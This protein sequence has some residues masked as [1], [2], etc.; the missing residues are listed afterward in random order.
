[1]FQ[2]VLCVY[3]YRI[4]LKR[5]KF[6]PP[7][8]IEYIGTVVEPH[9][10]ALDIIDLRKESACTID[11]LRPETDMVCFSI[12]WKRDMEFLHSE[13]RSVPPDILTILGGQQVTD[14]PESWFAAL[15][16]VDVIVRGEGEEIME[17]LC[18]G[19]PLENI[20]GLSFRRGDDIFHN[21][22][23]R[24]RPLSDHLYPNRS[25]RR[26]SYELEISGFNTGIEFDMLSASR[27]CPFKCT[28]CSFNRN[29]WGQ[30]RNWS[31]RSPES[32]VEELDLIKAPFIGLSDE[33]FTYDMDWVERICDLILARGIRKK[34]IV[35]ARLEI[36]RRP[37]VIRKMEQAGFAI[38]MLGVE[39]AQDKTLRSMRKGFNTAKIRE[40][41][42]VLRGRLIILHG[43]FILG[44]IGESVSEMKQIVP[45]ARELGLDTLNLCM[46]HTL[47]HSGIEDMVAQNPNYHIASNGK[48]YSDHCSIKEL[49]RLRSNLFEQFY[50]KRQ[51][52]H[53]MDKATRNGF[54][55]HFPQLLLKMPQFAI[56]VQKL[57]VANPGKQ[58]FSPWVNQP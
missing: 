38:L 36:A 53:I 58:R 41:F 8:G 2:H 18:R 45:F 42:D 22:S 13:I 37:D 31:G 48:V 32:I 51:M 52:L 7:S 34:Y 4:G 44:N 39:S 15:P 40:Y 5:F 21:S 54:L 46:L 6:C 24:L 47:P 33:L 12:N 1:M 27:G 30:K 9:T 50:T 29:P 43:Y 16:N 10:R 57:F 3:P 20:A 25:L 56:S 19:V 14:D 35:N 49:K 28:F 17:E 26:Y 11:F 55:K 23:R